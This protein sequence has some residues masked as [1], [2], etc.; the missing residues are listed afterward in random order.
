VAIIFDSFFRGPGVQDTTSFGGSAGDGTDGICAP[1]PPLKKKPPK[2][3]SQKD[4]KPNG[5]TWLYIL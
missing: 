2:N 4:V 5:Y 3:V 1:V